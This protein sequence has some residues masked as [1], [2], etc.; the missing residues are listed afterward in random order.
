MALETRTAHASDSVRIQLVRCRPHD[1]ACG[2]LEYGRGDLLVLPLRGVFV[3]HLG[4][5]ERVVADPCN[6][7]FFGHGEPYRV[8]HP[9]HAGDDCLVIEPA[10]NVLAEILEGRRIE[11]SHTVLD[12]RAIGERRMLA[13][14]LDAGLATHL[15]SEET[16]LGLL[17]RTL[18]ALGTPR[19]TSPRPGRR[20]ARHEEMVEA[21]KIALAARPGE[22][23][24][25]SA[26][27]GRVASSPFRLAR[28]FREIA[29]MPVHRY[30]VLARLSAALDEVL[31][32]SRGITDIGVG[33][34]FSSHSH[35]TAAFCR[36]FGVTPSG[37]RRGAP[38]TAQPGKI[39]TAA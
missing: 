21:T 19:T 2:P 31:G 8:S 36:A 37:L 15:E 35:F 22:D 10:H 28:L 26:L 16:A 9:A 18:S 5:R 34:G 32:S 11:R 24:R 12:A 14:R 38:L 39:S 27:A 29:G 20:R 13:H 33:L 1:H 23:W 30:L 17:A 4:P 6:A 7:L 3:R 25:L